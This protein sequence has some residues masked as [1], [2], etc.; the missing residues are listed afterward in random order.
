[1]PLVHGHRS[2]DARLLLAGVAAAL[3]ALGLVTCALCRARRA[4]RGNRRD[5][6]RTSEIPMAAL[7]RRSRSVS[8]PSS[9]PKPVSG[10]SE[11]TPRQLGC[12]PC[13]IPPGAYS[14]SSTLPASPCMALCR[15]AC[16]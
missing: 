15:A 11:G 3:L 9:V 7:M 5:A 14:S 10:A 2:P 13:V 6:S 8:A 16:L 12:V 1:V 4:P